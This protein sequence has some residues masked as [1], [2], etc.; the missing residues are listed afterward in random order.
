MSTAIL[1]FCV[2]RGKKAK[3]W[4]HTSGSQEQKRSY[5]CLVMLPCVNVHVSTSRRPPSLLRPF[6][7]RILVR[8]LRDSVQ[9]FFSVS[10]TGEETA[11]IEG[12]ALK[13][14]CLE[15]SRRSQII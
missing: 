10:G 2:A 12:M 8:C 4:F 14:T 7:G 13:G 11:V 6:P 9:S 15:F 1:T 5:D 3:N